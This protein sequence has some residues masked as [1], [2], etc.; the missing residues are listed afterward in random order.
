MCPLDVRRLSVVCGGRATDGATGLANLDHNLQVLLIEAGE[1]NLNNPWVYRPGIYPRNMKLDS[2]TASFYYSRPS[3]WLD[4]R[5]AIVPAAHVLGGGSSINFMMYTRASA[6]DY[7]D[8]QAKGWSTRELIPLMRKHETYQRA[9]NNRDIHGFEGPIKVSFGNYTY[10]IMQDFLRAAE[11][12]GFPI[13]DDLQDLVTGSV[14]PP[15]PSILTQCCTDMVPS[16]GSSGSTATR[17]AALMLRPLIS[18]PPVPNT[19]TFTF[20]AT[21]KS[22]GWSLK[23][24]GPSVSSLCPRNRSVERHPGHSGRPANWSLSVAVP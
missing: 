20:N 13:T 12:Q 16:T 22:T 24:A 11:S 7:D 19:R 4:G 17:A 10:P 8:F 9:C 3:E 21:R 18:T 5:R 2:K 15:S 6:S 23:M 1:N 14:L